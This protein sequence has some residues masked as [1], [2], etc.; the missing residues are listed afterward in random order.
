VA[1]ELDPKIDKGFFFSGDKVWTCYRRN[2]FSVNV[3]YRLSPCMSNAQL[4]L[5]QGGS[6]PLKCI[7]SIAVSLAA[8]VD[9][10]EGKRIELIQAT[11]R[12]NKRPQLMVKKDLLA[13]NPPGI[14]HNYISY[15]TNNFNSSEQIA[16]PQLPLRRDSERSQQ[17]PP[18]G[19]SNNDYR[20]TFE[21]IQFKSATSINRKRRAQQQYYHLIVE[22]WANIQNPGDTDP[23]WV[24]VAARLSHPVVVRGR[25]P[26]H[27]QGGAHDKTSLQGTR[28]VSLGGS[29]DHGLGS[30]GGATYGG[31]YCNGFAG[32][33]TFI[34]MIEPHN[35]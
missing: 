5:D 19:H 21:R 24:K 10:V 6:E 7:Q 30:G 9:G 1:L 12:R 28:I 15:R 29:V 2:Y 13:P 8:T 16:G 31:D 4:C 35:G 3:S 25:S 11:P 27:Y 23:R 18:T 33:K 14:I 32:S 22:L 34:N 20:H 17:Y 26:S